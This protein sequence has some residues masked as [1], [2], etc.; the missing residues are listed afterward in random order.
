VQF[1]RFTIYI[2]ALVSVLGTFILTAPAANAQAQPQVS[3]NGSVVDVSPPPIIQAGRVFVPLRGVFEQLGASV[4]YSNGTI[5]ATGNGRDITLQIGSTQATVNDQ[6]QTIDVAPFIV[7]ASTYVPLRFISE[8]LG[9]SVSWDEADQIAEINT[10]GGPADYFSP[11]TASY[12]DTPPPPIPVYDQPYVPEPN[13]IW[14]PGYWGWGA[15]GYYWVPGTWVQAPQSGYLWTPGY[16]QSNNGGYNWSPGYWAITVGFYGG[17][18]YGCGYFGQGYN[19]GR[20]SNNNFQYNTYV[21]RVN[22]TTINNVYVDRTVYVNKSTTRISY[23]GG[24]GGVPARPT[25]Q[26]LA[27]AKGRHLG[28]T[29][30]QQQ[31][32]LAAEQ[33]R[34]LLATVNHAKPPV[35]AVARPLS[36]SNR[37]PGFVAVK[38]TDR[39]NPQEHIAPVRVAPATV[40]RAAAP[41]AHAAAPAAHAAVAPAAAPAAHAAVAPAAPA[42]APAAHAPAPAAHAPAPA[43]HAVAPAARI[44]APVVH[45]PLAPVVHAPPAQAAPPGPRPAVYAAPQLHARSAVPVHPAPAAPKPPAPKPPA[46]KPPAPK[47]PAA[48]PAPA[49]PAPPSHA[50]PPG[51]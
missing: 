26:E 28:M 21:T 7:G 25:V 39:V 18:N 51:H 12:V 19:G 45:A 29:P 36:A 46:P 20:W 27:V 24:N 4:V 11:G 6:P 14:Q 42:P 47:P 43:A 17:I 37:P 22:T 15:Y 35:G 2:T 1:K 32:V 5:N 9:D 13:Y 38:A 44:P 33:D 31:H 8:A 48:K 34:A 23:N 40:T 30:A 3:V 10:G 49:H 41:A 50:P 16:W